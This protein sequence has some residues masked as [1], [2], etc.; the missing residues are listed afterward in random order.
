[1]KTIESLQDVIKGACLID[2]PISK[3]TTF[4]IGGNA[5][6]WVEPAD[7]E[8]L[9]NILREINREELS[10]R[11]IGNGSN[12]LAG[13]N[14]LPDVVI[15]LT[16]F[17]NTGVECNMVRAGSGV[18]ISRLIGFTIEDGL[19]GLE[20]LAGIPG[21]VGGSIKGNAG[22]HGRC[23]ADVLKEVT[24]MDKYGNTDTIKREKIR[25]KYRESDIGEDVIIL[26][27]VFGLEYGNKNAIQELVRKYLSERKRKIPKEPSAG[28]IFRNPHNKSAG[29]IIEKSGFKGFSMG[30]AMVS[31]E[32]ANIIINLEGASFRDVYSLIKHIQD[33]VFRKTGIR[34]EREVVIWG[35][36]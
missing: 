33:E 30:K 27:A 19:S 18:N 7:M 29:E 10:W 31:S 13:E 21:S 12:I 26:E 24:V 25:F 3:H 9:K 1:M 15:R 6:L 22:S 17:N 5:G 8:D 2:E 28:C 20:F 35:D 16:N 32:H 36:V 23:V 34:M 11:V 14:G 4:H